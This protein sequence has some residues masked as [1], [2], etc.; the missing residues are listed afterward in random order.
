VRLRQVQEALVAQGIDR[1]RVRIAMSADQKA[2]A[3]ELSALE[4][5]KE[6]ERAVTAA[7]PPAAPAG[8]EIMDPGES[9]PEDAQPAQKASAPA[10]A[11]NQEPRILIALAFED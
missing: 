4:A 1:S 5:Q 10:P 7:E 2:A 9:P 6:L 11:T 8:V 3:S